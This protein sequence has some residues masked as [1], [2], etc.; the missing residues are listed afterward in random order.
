MARATWNGRVIADSNDTV[1]V[2]GTHYFPLDS[3]D[4]SLLRES[5]YTRVCSWKGTARYY[6]LSVNGRDNEN[7]AWC[8]PDPRPA[9]RQIKSR[10]AFWKGVSVR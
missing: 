9:A 2:E 8:Y 1:V 7:A 5:A 6:T 4:R 3:V 10:V